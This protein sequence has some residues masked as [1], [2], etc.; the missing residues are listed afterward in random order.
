M[1]ATFRIDQVGP[2]TGTLDRSR[3]DLV[4]GAVI[5]LVV[6]SPVSGATYS[7]ELL[8][9][10]GSTAVLSAATGTTVTIGNSAAIVDFCGFSIKCTESILGIPDTYTIRVCSVRSSV[11]GIRP[12]LFRESADASSTVAAPN[13][14][15]STDNATYSDLSGRGA[16]AQNYRGWC[17][18]I[19]ETQK[20]LNTARTAATSAAAAAAAA[21]SSADTHATRHLSAG[22]DEIDGDK[23]DIDYVAVNFTSTTASGITTSTAQLSSYLKGIDLQ[24]ATMVTATTTA[25]SA[26]DAHA[27]RHL[28]AQADEIDADK[29][30]I[31]YVAVNFTSTTASGIT[32]TTAHLSSYL[33][34]IDLQIATI[35]AS[36]ATKASLDLDTPVVY[37]GTSNSASTADARK[38]IESSNASPN[39]LTL[40]SGM[41]VGSITP[42]QQTGAGETT[43]AG[44]GGSV[45]FRTPGGAK[46]STQYAMCYLYVRSATEYVLTGSTKT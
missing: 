20:A 1:A 13:T 11:T 8:D 4:T 45:N 26:A 46:S 39:T 17:E 41:P 34:G 16:S 37:T 14:S 18:A 9:T 42:L 3:H 36:I 44:P 21:Q 31:D 5:T 43:Y 29:L 33:K 7:W 10:V 35:N 38:P 32:T 25:Q 15:G 24:L 23:L 19:Y 40:P 22:L 27:G 30:D 6:P 28:S 2:G 12:V